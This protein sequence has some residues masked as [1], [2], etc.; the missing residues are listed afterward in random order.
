MKAR[1]FRPKEPLA[2]HF[3]D[4]LLRNAHVGIAVA[5]DDLRRGVEPHQLQEQAYSMIDRARFSPWMADAMRAYYQEIIGR[6]LRQFLD[7]KAAAK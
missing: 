2:K 5:L 3:L 7:E 1:I 6:A 4:K